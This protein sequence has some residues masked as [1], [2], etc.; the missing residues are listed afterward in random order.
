MK[1]SGTVLLSILFVLTLVGLI[2]GQNANHTHTTVQ[3][4]RDFLIARRTRARLQ[5]HVLH[6]PKTYPIVEREEAVGLQEFYVARKLLLGSRAHRLYSLG[7][8]LLLPEQC[9]PD[10]VTF[11][12]DDERHKAWSSNYTCQIGLNPL[13]SP[14]RTHHNLRVIAPLESLPEQII[15]TNGSFFTSET[16]HVKHSLLLIAGGDIELPHLSTHDA[17]SLVDIISLNGTIT[18]RRI[19]GLTSLYLDALKSVYTPY[20]TTF[21]DTPRLITESPGWVSGLHSRRSDSRKR[22]RGNIAQSQ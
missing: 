21:R 9:E 15:I 20:G 19:S 18:I 12:N 3:T 2:L 7:R 22:L 1:D 13:S 4:V 10:A 17:T 5:H 8:Y 6:A 11:L 14:F 16:L